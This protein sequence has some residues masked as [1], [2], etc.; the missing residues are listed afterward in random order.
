MR[1]FQ[2]LTRPSYGHAGTGCAGGGAGDRII[3]III[4]TGGALSRFMRAQIT[5][6]DLPAGAL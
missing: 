1:P 5:R 4:D 2:T 6:S 3:N